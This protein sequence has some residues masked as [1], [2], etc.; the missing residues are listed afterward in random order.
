[1]QLW[2]CMALNVPVVSQVSQGCWRSSPMAC[3]PWWLGGMIPKEQVEVVNYPDHCKSFSFG[4]TVAAFTI[5]KRATCI[6]Y[7]VQSF[8]NC[9][10]CKDCSNSNRAHINVF[11]EKDRSTSFMRLLELPYEPW[12]IKCTLPFRS[13]HSFGIWR[14][15][16]RIG[17]EIN[18]K[19]LMQR[20]R[21]WARLRKRRV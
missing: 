4:L 19:S 21:Y 6:G 17:A 7:D 20:A 3:G 18:E 1:M 10:L 8:V 5:S 11:Q 13:S 16:L 2:F 14:V 12:I 15:S 9:Y